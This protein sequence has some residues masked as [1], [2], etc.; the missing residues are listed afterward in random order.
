M[1]MSMR[2][3]FG[4]R[5]KRDKVDSGQQRRPVYTEVRSVSMSNLYS[6]K[7]FLIDI[8]RHYTIKQR[9][10]HPHLPTLIVEYVPIYSWSNPQIQNDG[11]ER[12]EKVEDIM[13]VELSHCDT[14]VSNSFKKF[15]AVLGSKLD[16]RFDHIIN[17]QL[18]E[19]VEFGAGICD[20]SQLTKIS[21]RDFMCM[22]GGYGYYNYK[23]KSAGMTPKYPPGLYYYIQTCR[24]IRH[25]ADICQSGD[26]LTIVVQRENVNTQGDGVNLHSR[27]GSERDLK[28]NAMDNLKASLRCTISFYK[29][30]E[31]MGFHL[32]NL[33]GPF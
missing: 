25:E 8:L 27:F 24:K 21:S 14:V 18:V 1:S 23:T 28:F 26:V 5:K 30:G 17:L 9:V 13:K 4:L 12:D 7:D 32:R 16:P 20:E 6:Y 31:D 19:G 15:G 22:K 3:K 11:D 29:N 33:M 2:A 10:Y